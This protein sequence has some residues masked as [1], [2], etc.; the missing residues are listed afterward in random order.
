MKTKFEKILNKYKPV[1]PYNTYINE[2]TFISGVYL[3]EE[4]FVKT[5]VNLSNF[6]QI[7]D[8]IQNQELTLI[9]FKITIDIL[10]NNQKQEYNKAILLDSELNIKHEIKIGSFQISYFGEIK[11]DRN[12]IMKKGEFHMFNQ[13]FYGRVILGKNR[14]ACPS[15]NEYLYHYNYMLASLKNFI[16]EPFNFFP[17]TYLMNN[18]KF[19]YQASFY[20]KDKKIY[21]NILQ[22]QSVDYKEQ[23]TIDAVVI[24]MNPGSRKPTK[25]NILSNQISNV[26]VDCIPD[27]TQYQIAR[28]ME[29]SKWNKVIVINLL[30]LCETESTE[31]FQKYQN[32]L[33]CSS[34]FSDSRVEELNSIFNQLNNSKNVIV[35]WGVSS[36][37]NNIKS[38][39]LEFIKSKNLTPVGWKNK[40]NDFYHPWPRDNDEFRQKWPQNVYDLLNN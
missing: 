4:T 36:D 18:S 22:I 40:Y 11:N 13:P 14:I 37:L 19:R 31:V 17:W 6:D 12:Q 34:I 3:I 16:N 28:L 29:L 5:N 9:F 32:N 10:D 2:K 21:S 25:S 7:I 27:D 23:E 33:P 20:Y 26:L 38:K 30:D 1:Y 39:A 24:M 15:E 35:G 8:I